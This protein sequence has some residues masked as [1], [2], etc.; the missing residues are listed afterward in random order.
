MSVISLKVSSW[1]SL[2]QIPTVRLTFVQETIV[3]ATFL[4]SFSLQDGDKK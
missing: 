1:D 3:L 4:A 2:E